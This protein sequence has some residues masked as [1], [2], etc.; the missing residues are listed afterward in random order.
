MKPARPPSADPRDVPGHRQLRPAVHLLPDGIRHRQRDRR[1]DPSGAPPG[2]ERPARADDEQDQREDRRDEQNLRLGLA[3]DTGDD[4]GG[5]HGRAA[6]ANDSPDEQP[7]EGRGREQVERRRRDEVAD[8][9]RDPGRRGAG[10]RDHLSPARPSDLARDERREHRRRCRHQLGG[11]PQQEQRSRRDLLH[12]P[13]D[14]RDDRRL[15]RVSE[16]GMRARGDEVHLVAVIAVPGARGDQRH[17]LNRYDEADPRRQG[18]RRRRGRY[19]RGS[20]AAQ[21]STRTTTLSPRASQ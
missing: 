21:P 14:E 13:R 19:F 17:Q 2:H 5:E 9:E 12:R 3:P 8:R 1:G 11:Q 10:R 6:P 4:A 18:R 15:V 20:G 7:A 16:R